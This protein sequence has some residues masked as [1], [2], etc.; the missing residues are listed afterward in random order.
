MVQL[1][2]PASLQRMRSASLQE[3]MLSGSLWSISSEVLGGAAR[4]FCYFIYAKLLSPTDF[5]LI[6][7]CLLLINLFP[8]LIDNSLALALIRQE[9]EDHH[10]FSVIFLLNVGLS[11]VA[12]AVLCI[13]APWTAEFLH[14]RR[15]TL[16]LPVLSIQL[17]CNAL[18]STHIAIARRRF[19]YARLVP[20]KL[21]STF[22]S[23]AFGL[24]FAF[25]GNGYWALIA[26]S[27][28]TSLGQMLAAW[29][30]LPWRPSFRFEWRTARSL[31]G[32]ASWVA[33]DMGITWLVISGG[34]FFL[35]FYLGT[36]ELGLFR[37]SDQIDTYILG[38]VIAP[39]IPVLYSAFCEVGGDAEQWRRLFVRS[40]Q[41]VA[42]VSLLSQGSS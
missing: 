28:A 27:I 14:D 32:F 25:R 40:L 12:I 39:L 38:A 5:G 8:L 10:T 34:G 29:A 11:I 31:A 3:R 9:K 21:F 41:I 35:A 13:T 33:T 37:L 30:L 15:V 2:T 19:R 7:F 42:T 20:V 26:A 17:L 6:G 18:C 16:V 4:A 36:R 1:P 24:I 22:C 23:L